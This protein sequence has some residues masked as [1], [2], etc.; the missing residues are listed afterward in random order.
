MMFFNEP[1]YAR[2]ALANSLVRIGESPVWI[3]G[4][5]GDWST[6]LFFPMNGKRSYIEDIR[7]LKGLN[8]EP[9]PLGYVNKRDGA[10]YVRRIPRRRWKQ[11]L[12][13]DSVQGRIYEKDLRSKALGNC[14]LGR[15]PSLDTALE[16][17][18]S[19]RTSVAFHRH[20]AVQVGIVSPSL[21]YKEKNVGIIENG[22]L[23][24]VPDYEY[25]TES[26]E[27]IVN[28]DRGQ[29]I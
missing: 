21:L 1:H 24:L 18:N 9:V 2:Q 7:T 14:V 16:L 29:A 8:I 19:C 27:E 5:E 13:R 25:L 12:S 17:L 4:V 15:Y 20:W 3:E 11:G 26:L 10:R 6:N 28:V 22:I 23:R